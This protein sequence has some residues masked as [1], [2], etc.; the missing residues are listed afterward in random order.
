VSNSSV[1]YYS[2]VSDDH[3]AFP[4]GKYK[5]MPRH[6]LPQVVYQPD[7][8]MNELDSLVRV[9]LADDQRRVENL[10]EIAQ[11]EASLRELFED[12]Q[13]IHPGLYSGFDAFRSAVPQ[14]LAKARQQID[15]VKHEV[16]EPTEEEKEEETLII[17]DVEKTLELT[18]K[19]PKLVTSP[20]V[21]EI[22]DEAERVLHDIEGPSN[23]MHELEPYQGPD[24]PDYLTGPF[25]TRDHPV[26]VPSFFPTR[27]VGCTGDHHNDHGTLWHIVN[28]SRPTICMEC[29]QYFKLKRLDEK[30]LEDEVS[31]KGD[32]SIEYLL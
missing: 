30:L 28:E 31:N 29:G 16:G 6:Q 15:Q 18:K 5:H 23:R 7:N 9:I 13:K 3:E 2:S 12:V 27:V 8:V 17:P 4:E 21:R 1:R 26:L 32:A 19:D 22:L 25:G 24:Y 10:E 11:N 20:Q 14:I